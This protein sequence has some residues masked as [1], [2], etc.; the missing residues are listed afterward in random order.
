MEPARNR[1]KMAAVNAR[2]GRL[3]ITPLS[4]VEPDPFFSSLKTEDLLRLEPGGI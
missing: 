3:G 4:L 2:T 1:P